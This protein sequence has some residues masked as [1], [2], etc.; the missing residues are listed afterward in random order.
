MSRDQSE[1]KLTLE[2]DRGKTAI[3]SP[4]PLLQVSQRR[5]PDCSV[6]WLAEELGVIFGLDK[7]LCVSMFSAVKGTSSCIL[8]KDFE[9][10][11]WESC[12]RCM[13][14]CD[15]VLS[16]KNSEQNFVFKQLPSN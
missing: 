2:C 11:T 8:S 10:S 6:A 14:S 7:T 16:R 13:D 5:R 9:G 3:S 12:A 4:S 1:Q 15:L